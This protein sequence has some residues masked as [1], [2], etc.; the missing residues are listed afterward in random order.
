MT[1]AVAV[2]TEADRNKAVLDAYG[3]NEQL[4]E[5]G[6]AVAQFRETASA[7][8]TEIVA[9]LTQIADSL[10][11]ELRERVMDLVRNNLGPRQQ[12][13]LMLVFRKAGEWLDEERKELERPPSKFFSGLRVTTREATRRLRDLDY[14]ETFLRCLARDVLRAMAEH[15]WQR[16]A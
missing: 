4:R 3:L 1:T 6:Q 16:M 7:E 14:F 12:A 8:Q 11:Y 10:N 5:L 9:G 13:N 15:N 2:M